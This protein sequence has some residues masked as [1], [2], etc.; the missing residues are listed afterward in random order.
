VIAWIETFGLGMLLEEM[1]L[2]HHRQRQV[3]HAVLLGDANG[4]HFGMSAA[5]KSCDQTDRRHRLYN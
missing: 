1:L 3:R 5:C 4:V 2:L